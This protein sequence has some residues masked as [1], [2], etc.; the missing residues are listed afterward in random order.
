MNITKLSLILI[1]IF[2]LNSLITIAEEQNDETDENT[3][4]S[5]GEVTHLT[6]G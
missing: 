6:S 4:I 5:T 3:L 1:V 2:T